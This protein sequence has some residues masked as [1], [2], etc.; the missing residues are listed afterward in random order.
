MSAIIKN[1]NAYRLGI[2]REVANFCEVHD[3]ACLLTWGSLLGAVREGG[4]IPWDYDIDLMMPREDYKRF[5]ETFQSESGRYQLWDSETTQEFKGK[6]GLVVDTCTECVN[7]KLTEKSP[8]KHL[9]VEIYVF[10]IAP[11]DER[12][13]EA[14]LVK[15]GKLSQINRLKTSYWASG[16]SFI[17]NVA[18]L[19][20]RTVLAPIP[21]LRMMRKAIDKVEPGANVQYASINS[22]R[23]YCEWCVPAS[24][25]RS[26]EIVNFSGVE[27]RIPKDYHP[28]LSFLYGDYMTPPSAEDRKSSEALRDACV[29]RDIRNE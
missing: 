4:I 27:C 13:R 1:P 18:S 20:L 14:L 26:T 10:D 12:E 21:E 9:S 8:I 24:F 22:I 19:V 29:Y 23:P 7:L 5:V 15:M 25:F 6:L 16:R 3:I 11:S 28:F 17:K 2:L